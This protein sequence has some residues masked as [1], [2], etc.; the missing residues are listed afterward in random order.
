[1][2]SKH[3]K[4]ISS[5]AGMTAV[6]YGR[7]SSHGQK[8]ASIEQQ[9]AENRA[10][11]TREGIIIVDEYADRH[12][13]GTSDK[14]PAFQRMIRD[15]NKGH[16]QLVICWKVDRFARNREDAAIYKGRL[17]SHGVKVLYAKEPIPE[18]SAGILLETMLEGTAEWYSATLSENVVRGMRDNALNCRINNASMPLGYKRG[19]D[20]KYALNP[21][22][23][24][25]VR[26]IYELY[27]AGVRLNDIAITLNNRGLRT[28]RGTFF[29]IENLRK[30]IRNERYTG[31]YI[32]DDIRIEGG[33]PQI[34][35]QELFDKVKTI[36]AKRAR[37]P[38]TKETDYLL[39]GKLFCGHCGN[40]MTG[41]TGT[42]KS[43]RIYRYYKCVAQKRQHTCD[44]KP[45]PQAWIERLVTELT[46]KAV[47]QDDI[48]TQ[49]AEA[50]VRIQLAE[51]ADDSELVALEAR[52]RDI[53]RSLDNVMNAIE[54]GII[55]PTTKA[56]MQEL[57]QQH[58]ELE[59]AI[60]DAQTI[61]P[62]YTA[63]QIIYMLE[64]YRDGDI[65]DPEYQRKILHMFVK[66]VYLYDDKIEIYYDYIGQGDTIIS[67]TLSPTEVFNLPVSWSTKKDKSLSGGFFFLYSSH[68]TFYFL[69]ESEKDFV[70]DEAV[71]SLCENMLRDDSL[72]K[73]IRGVGKDG[74][75]FIQRVK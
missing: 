72:L 44:K 18:G 39:S 38:R 6:L 75:P 14:R 30:I 2:A 35:T 50:V 13:S 36:I 57:E 47:L 42:S 33:I 49:I 53:K 5:Y 60:S 34:I 70:E 66:V 59:V 73:S 22:A 68:F 3:Q 32:Y 46:V 8:D 19:I 24:A 27:A 23:A 37:A 20:G 28:S 56:R 10:Y 15:A 16:F 11:A 43:G 61:R 31:V 52:Q 69:F 54:Q 48:I 17:R 45:A 21:D 64:R 12:L 74:R 67:H 40:L 55:T 51:R 29:N 4:A 9:F 1:M 71:A 25:I 63:D 41:E 62:M 7:Y 58:A 26:E 65:E